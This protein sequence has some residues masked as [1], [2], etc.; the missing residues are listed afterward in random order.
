[1]T[2]PSLVWRIFFYV[3]DAQLM[4]SFCEDNFPPDMGVNRKQPNKLYLV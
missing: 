3:C 2:L 4:Q 1:M